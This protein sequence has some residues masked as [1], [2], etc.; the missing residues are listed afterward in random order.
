MS[1]EQQ[2]SC[3][4]ELDVGNYA[5]DKLQE[6]QEGE[7]GFDF[8]AS[9]HHGIGHA[10]QD[11]SVPAGVNSRHR[12]I[13]EERELL[14]SESLVKV[15][16]L[17]VFPNSLVGDWSPVLFGSTEIHPGSMVVFIINYV[18]FVVAEVFFILLEI[19]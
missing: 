10:L 1:V 16:P 18:H 14:H 5:R 19:F 2:I 8:V 17:N 9:L 12:N 7:V 4:V 11:S 3:C 13:L 15:L 6:D